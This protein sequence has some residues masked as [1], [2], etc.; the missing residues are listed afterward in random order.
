LPDIPNNLIFN[1]IIQIKFYRLY[2]GIFGSKKPGIRIIKQGAGKRTLSLEDF[3]EDKAQA[4][5]YA[6]EN[7]H[8]APNRMEFMDRVSIWEGVY[9]PLR[10]KEGWVQL[11]GG[12][13]SGDRFKIEWQVG[14]DVIVASQDDWDGTIT[15]RLKASKK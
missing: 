5:L 4:R 12:R 10:E 11:K 2:M 3:I 13:N 7:A 14:Q 9:I 15:E 1:D 6:K 8:V